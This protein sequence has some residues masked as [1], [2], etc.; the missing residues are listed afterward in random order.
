MSAVRWAHAMGAACARKRLVACG[1]D[2]HLGCTRS[3]RRCTLFH[4]SPIPSAL[5]AQN[6]R[7]SP[8]QSIRAQNGAW[9]NTYLSCEEDSTAGLLRTQRARPSLAQML[10]LHHS[11]PDPC[12]IAKWP[13]NPS[14]AR[15][16]TRHA[17]PRARV[18]ERAAEAAKR[19]LKRG[20]KWVDSGRFCY[21][22][23]RF[24]KGAFARGCCRRF[25]GRE[26]G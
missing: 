26:S 5:R 7:L 1:V 14:V 22:P 10:L 3:H 17:T 15:P 9:A 23:E 11:H 12:F 19:E 24:F 4:Q 6:S 8:A 16:P 20:A 2:A 25:C 18:G 13:R 21:L